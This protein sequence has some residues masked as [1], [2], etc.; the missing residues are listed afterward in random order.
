MTGVLLR[1]TCFKDL[2][3]SS[4]D[5]NLKQNNYI[6]KTLTFLSVNLVLVLV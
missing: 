5:K 4:N 2:D 1:V 6:F 3:V